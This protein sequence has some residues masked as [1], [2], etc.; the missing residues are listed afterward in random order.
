MPTPKGRSILAKLSDFSI[1]GWYTRTFVDFI[2]AVQSAFQHRNEITAGGL[3]TTGASVTASVLQVNM[4]AMNVTL[5]GRMKAQVTALAN[6]DLF[7]TAGFVGRATYSDGTDASGIALATNKIARVSVIACNSNGAGGADNLENGGVKIVAIVS[8][9]GVTYGNKTAPP[10]SAEI[11]AA[12]TAAT[13][14]HAGTTAWSHV[15][16]ILWNENNASP[17]ATVTSNRNNVVQAI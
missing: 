4:A 7:T 17:S 10:T 3:V 15:A 9:T 11:T 2:L 13:G 16:T 1:R 12:L 14:I 8:G 5:D 6:V